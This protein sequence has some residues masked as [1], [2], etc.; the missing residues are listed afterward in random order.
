M[1]TTIEIPEKLRAELLRIAGKRGM[2][3][4]SL[5]I[6]EA[7]EQYL[8]FEN[9]RNEKTKHALLAKGALKDTGGAFEERVKE[10]R[11]TWRS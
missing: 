2:K 8:S 9:D 6:Q 4:F 3:G 5:I 7:L 11:K 10:L 1:R